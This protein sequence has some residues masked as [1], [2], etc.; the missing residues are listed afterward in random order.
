MAVDV[1]H[2]LGCPTD[3]STCKDLCSGKDRLLHILML[4]LKRSKQIST[5]IFV[6][7]AEKTTLNP[8]LHLG[9]LPFYDCTLNIKICSSPADFPEV[10]GASIRWELACVL[11][12]NMLPSVS[13]CI[14]AEHLGRGRQLEKAVSLMLIN[15]SGT[16]NPFMQCDEIK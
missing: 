1:Q 8:S 13:A 9:I 4:F 5:S 2:G 3:K 10:A 12:A 6:L 7:S 11:I 15:T 16:V 14:C